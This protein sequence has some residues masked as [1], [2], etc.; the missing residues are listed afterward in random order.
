MFGIRSK[1]LEI[2]ANWPK[3]EQT[4]KTRADTFR[5]R[6]RTSI[7]SGCAAHS[8]GHAPPPHF[9]EG[10]AVETVSVAHAAPSHP[11]P[12]T[13]A[14]DSSTNLHAAAVLCGGTPRVGPHPLWSW[15]RANPGRTA[16]RHAH[17][18]LLR[19]RRMLPE[20]TFLAA[21]PPSCTAHSMR[22]PVAHGRLRQPSL[23]PACRCT[24]YLMPL[25]HV[26]VD[27]FAE[28]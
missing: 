28:L 10:G 24:S 3:M 20:R 15:R 2:C 14:P 17:G 19:S 11:A 7:A 5:R 26:L 18:T 27:A 8:H 21:R 9:S 13:P 16:A 4:F 23:A 25:A 1:G 6:S 22:C 12:A